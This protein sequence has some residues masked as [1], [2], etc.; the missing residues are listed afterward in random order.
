MNQDMHSLIYALIRQALYVTPV[1]PLVQHLFWHVPAL[2]FL[3]M[4]AELGHLQQSHLQVFT[5]NS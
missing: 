2:L 3:G 1:L 5:G 4:Q